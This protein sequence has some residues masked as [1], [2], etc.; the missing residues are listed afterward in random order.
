M[1]FTCNIIYKIIILAHLQLMSLLIKPEPIML[2]E[3]PIMLL[4]NAPKISLLCS[5]YAQSCPIM[6]W[7]CKY[8]FADEHSI[9]VYY[10]IVLEYLSYMVTAL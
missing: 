2:L 7:I 3:L 1:S 10:Y 5:N 9:R 4:S 8:N 6:P